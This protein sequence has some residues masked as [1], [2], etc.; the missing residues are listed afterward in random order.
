MAD[1]HCAMGAYVLIKKKNSFDSARQCKKI[2]GL[3]C[4]TVQAGR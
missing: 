4:A 2:S 3:G 1:H